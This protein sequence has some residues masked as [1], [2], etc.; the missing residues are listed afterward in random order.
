[1]FTPYPAQG[2]AAALTIARMPARIASGRVGHAAITTAKAGS[3]GFARAGSALE[4]PES[5]PHFA[6]LSDALSWNHVVEGSHPV[7]SN[8]VDERLPRAV[9]AGGGV[10]GFDNADGRQSGSFI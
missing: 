6:P 2:F 4:S 5:A 8:R 10:N 9:I 1:M 7:R 3:A